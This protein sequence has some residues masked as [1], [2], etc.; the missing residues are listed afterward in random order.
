MTVSKE[1][2]FAARLPSAEVEIPG[3]GTVRVRGLSRG[4][5]FG[6]QN[7]KGTAAVERKIL[8]FGMVDPAL[9]EPE[10]QRWQEASPAGELDEV[11]DKIRELSGLN[12]KAEKEA[13]LDF[14]EGAEPGVR[15]V[16]GGQAVD[17]GGGTAGADG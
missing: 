13:V 7:A 15:D 10:V 12:D 2:L 6:V 9:T 1:E 16:P 14:R 5:V 17:D 8:A 4:E 3:V 11:V